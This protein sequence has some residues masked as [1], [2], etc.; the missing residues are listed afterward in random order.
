MD[1]EPVY[2]DNG[3]I[4]MPCL[5]VSPTA[6]TAY[7][8]L[9]DFNGNFK[10]W[11]TGIKPPCE[12]KEKGF[13]SKKGQKA[14][15]RAVYWFLYSVDPNIV[16]SGKGKEKITFL[17]LTLPSKQVHSDKEIK[18]KCLKQFLTEIR[19]K[20]EVEKFIW[21]AEKQ[22]QG[23]LHFHILL[24]KYIDAKEV[25]TIWN[26]IINKLHYVYE[27]H[28]KMNALSWSDYRDMRLKEIKGK[29][30]EKDKQRIRKA[31][32]AGC[33]ANWMNPNSTDI[34][35]LRK[36]GN[37]AAYVGKYMSKEHKGI[38]KENL[39][40]DGRIW[41]S[42]QSVSKMKNL[43][44]VAAD[45]MTYIE[46]FAD[47]IKRYQDT[48]KVYESEHALMLGVPI[49]QLKYKGY[50]TIPEEFAQYC[51][52]LFSPVKQKVIEFNQ[53]VKQEIKQIINNE[54]K[55]LQLCM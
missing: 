50:K 16:N 21:K 26:R 12:N 36:V 42:S 5:S 23:Q 30:S 48:N 49:D 52:E 55:Q 27:Y 13:I 34:E 25:R 3:L 38:A 10:T 6:V 14:L 43:L 4:R 39:K 40:V 45:D 22:G 33:A 54:P 8:R 29:P 41:F 46:E 47:M 1:L 35:N 37:I 32:K 17:T 20:Y 9:M 53:A 2:L 18:D 19:A 28:K 15:E 51:R 11:N 24:D 44:L 7:T 31:Y